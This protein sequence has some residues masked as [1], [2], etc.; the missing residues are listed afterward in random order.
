MV[1]SKCGRRVV[2][3]YLG[4]AGFD[5]HKLEEVGV[6][7]IVHRYSSFPVAPQQPRTPSLLFPNTHSTHSTDPKHVCP[8]NGTQISSLTTFLSYLSQPHI[9]PVLRA[10]FVVLAP[11]STSPPPTA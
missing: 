11:T 3:R 7:N 4:C 2:V 6:Y 9:S 8:R 5:R 1:L 10:V